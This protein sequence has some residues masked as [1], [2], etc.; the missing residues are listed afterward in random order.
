[1][2]ISITGIE[3]RNLA[4]KGLS[5][6]AKTVKESIGTFGL[7]LLSEKQNKIS[8]DGAFIAEQLIPTIENEFER[9]GAIVIHENVNKINDEVG[10]GSSTAWALHEAI[11]KECMRYL[12]NEKTI[13]AKKTYAEVGIM[14][15]RSK[16]EVINSLEK[17]VKPITSKEELIKSALVS[18]EDEKVAELLGTMQWDLGP[19][20]R[21]IAEE[22]ND[23]V[24]S[25]EKTNGIILDNG[26]VSSNLVTNPETQTFELNAPIPIILTNHVVGE[27]EMKI[28]RDNIF[29]T[30]AIQKKTGCIL[31]ARAFTKEA[32]QETQSNMKSFGVVLLNAPYTDQAEVMRDIESIVGGR[33][34]DSEESTL[35]DIYITDVGCANRIVARQYNSQIAG[36]DNQESK[37]RITKRIELLKKKVIGSQS[38]FEKRMINERIAQLAGGFAIL[39]VGSYSMADRKRLKD[40]SD[41]AVNAVRLALKGGVVKGAGQAFKEISDTMEEGNILKRPLTVVYDQIISSAPEDWTIPEWVNDPYLVLKT[42]LERTC[43]FIPTFISINA[44]VTEENPLKCKCKSDDHS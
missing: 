4:I 9:R 11:I 37:D 19:E 35:Q 16:N 31:M 36:I 13:K 39:K 1:M 28:L 10:D 5:F 8:N 34:I 17:M 20:G 21:I 23:K 3:A 27:P 12:P 7:N 2:K 14:I 41:D 15:E 18:C 33:Y 42:V 32:I 43:S 24:C 25:I 40:K 30:L 22:V 38:D 29:K 6:V 44:I 26:F